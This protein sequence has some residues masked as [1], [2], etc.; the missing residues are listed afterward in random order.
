MYFDVFNGEV[1]VTTGT[2]QSIRIKESCYKIHSLKNRKRMT[3]AL[4]VRLW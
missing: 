2:K 1:L 4:Q 3:G